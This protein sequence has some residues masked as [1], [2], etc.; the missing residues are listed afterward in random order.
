MAQ[1]RVKLVRSRIARKPC[2]KK[3]LDALGLTRCG[4]EKTFE[5]TP[6]I[7]GMIAKVSHL[8]EVNE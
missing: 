7:R 1:I 4:R 3:N 6:A 5:D 8:V 2:Q